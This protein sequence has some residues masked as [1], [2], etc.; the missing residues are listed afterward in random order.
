MLGD[1]GSFGGRIDREQIARDVLDS[2]PV[3]AACRHL[4]AERGSAPWIVDERQQRHMHGAESP[5]PHEPDQTSDP[6]A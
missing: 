6:E 3:A 5:I 4:G 1:R 2:E